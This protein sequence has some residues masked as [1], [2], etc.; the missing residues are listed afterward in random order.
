MKSSELPQLV[1]AKQLLKDVKFLVKEVG[2]RPTGSLAV[3]QV[4]KLVESRFQSCGFE[5]AR[6]SYPLEVP[7][8]PFAELKLD[9]GKIILGLPLIGIPPEQPYCISPKEGR[10]AGRLVDC[11]DATGDALPADLSGAIALVRNQ[12]FMPGAVWKVFDLCQRGAGAVVFWNEGTTDQFLFPLATMREEMLTMP[13]LMPRRIPVAVVSDKSGKILMKLAKRN[14]VVEISTASQQ[15]KVSCINVLGTLPGVGKLAQEIVLV[16]AHIDAGYE[17]P[18]IVGAEDNASGLAMVLEVARGISRLAQEAKHLSARRTMVFLAYDAEETNCF[19]IWSWLLDLKALLNLKGGFNALCEFEKMLFFGD[20]QWQQFAGT[21][22]FT[23][24]FAHWDR[25]ANTKVILE[26]DGCGIGDRL[27]IAH[28]VRPKQRF[29]QVIQGIPAVIGVPAD[30]VEVYPLDFASEVG[31]RATLLGYPT[32]Q[33]AFHVGD[34]SGARPCPHTPHDSLKLID[35]NSL[36][37]A[38]TA[39]L[40]AA[41]GACTAEKL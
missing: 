10:F 8:L 23:Q 15:H 38:A 31:R 21:G 30:H 13:L 11:G 14:G 40:V 12:Q 9:G 33:V 1:S 29:N 24:R 22:G 18:D 35:A 28:N 17:R 41:W 3:H 39:Y 36:R 27:Q 37:M 19:G 20:A 4:A 6:E 25:L 16:C 26:A 7:E 2:Y 34:A 5:I 32:H